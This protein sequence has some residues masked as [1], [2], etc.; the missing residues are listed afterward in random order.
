MI[1]SPHERRGRGFVIARSSPQVP[2]GFGEMLPVADNGTEEGR[3]RNRRVQLLLI[4]E[5][6]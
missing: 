5:V 3:R 1:R 6:R 4:P 2:H